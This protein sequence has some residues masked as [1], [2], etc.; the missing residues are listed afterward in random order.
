MND[1]RLDRHT[2]T[3]SAA[4]AYAASVGGMSDFIAN[5]L[6]A[7]Q[8]RCE[9]LNPDPQVSCSVH[10]DRDERIAEERAKVI[11]SFDDVDDIAGSLNP[12]QYQML[13]RAY[14][15]A[16]SGDAI[17]C[18]RLIE[19]VFATPVKRLA[20]NRVDGAAL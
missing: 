15:A 14:M 16:L 13:T 18:G 1:L 9:C 20:E 6:F 3:V 7:P 12:D 17:E 4:A 2:E 11:A 19:K 5:R 8:R 10:A